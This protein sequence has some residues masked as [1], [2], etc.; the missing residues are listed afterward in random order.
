MGCLLRFSASARVRVLLHVQ[1]NGDSGSPRVV[2]STIASNLFTSCGSEIRMGL[3]PAPGRRIRPFHAVPASI[4]RIPL[5]T[6]FRDRPH[7]RLTRLTPPY[8]KDLASLA[9]IRRLARSSSS[10]QTE[11]NFALNSAR[12]LTFQKNNADELSS[13]LTMLIPLFIYTALGTL[14]Q[15]ASR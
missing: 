6:A 10:G 12:V 8:P 7:A 15:G 4:S 11:R 13:L 9:A 5:P 1:R 14:R 3:R 2:S